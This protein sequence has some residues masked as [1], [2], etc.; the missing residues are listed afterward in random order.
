MKKFC[1]VLF[2]LLLCGCNS[3]KGS[4][5]IKCDDLKE[6]KGYNGTVIIDVRTN[7]EY[8]GIHIDNAINIP[9]EDFENEIKNHNNIN[10]DTP[11]VVYCK[12]GA[13]SSKAYDILKKLGYKHI[14]DLGAMGSC[15]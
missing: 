13:R 8:N 6:I 1:L 12:S 15:I 3:L 7:E 11:I 9:V 10:L 14:Y 5:K 4:G 2:C